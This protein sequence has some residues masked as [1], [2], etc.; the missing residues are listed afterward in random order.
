MKELTLKEAALAW[1]QGKRVQATGS[2]GRGDFYDIA[3]PGET[4]G[5]WGTGVFNPVNNDHKFRLA[6]EPPAKRFRPWTPEEVPVGARFRKGTP[7]NTSHCWMIVG[8]NPGGFFTSN[9]LLECISFEEA[10]ADFHS[11][12]HGK[13][14][15][16]CGVEVEA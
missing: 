9:E 11:T 10:L 5:H 16:P 7:S 8:W 1:A 14:W 2:N 13:T 6:P 12:D 15:L 4:S 3:K